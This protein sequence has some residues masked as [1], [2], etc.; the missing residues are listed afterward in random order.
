[1]IGPSLEVLKGIKADR[2][3]GTRSSRRGR[4]LWIADALPTRWTFKFGRPVQGESMA[5]RAKPLSMTVVTN[6]GAARQASAKCAEL[7][8]VLAALLAPDRPL[9]AR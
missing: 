5:T 1:M 7:K 6:S 3:T 4:L 2:S 8:S 9:C